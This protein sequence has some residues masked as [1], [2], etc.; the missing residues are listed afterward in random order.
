MKIQ[1]HDDRSEILPLCYY[2]HP[3]LKKKACDIKKVTSE[4]K[5]LAN[6]MIK[7]MYHHNG[8]GL[9]GPQVGQNLNLVVLDITVD[10]KVEKERIFSSPGEHDLLGKMPLVLVNPKLS[11][12]SEK[13]SSY[14][15]GCLSIPGVT[16]EVVR[17]EFLQF[18]C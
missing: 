15:E 5:E 10:D 13:K 17:P 2:G 14:V 3:S 6:K 8:I 16:A 4:I 9:A 12:L 1:P 7:T 18:E 11:K